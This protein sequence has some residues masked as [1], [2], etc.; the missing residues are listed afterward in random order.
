MAVITIDGPCAAG[1]TSIAKA[2]AKQTGFTYIDTGA[3]Y[4]VLAYRRREHP[5]ESPTS[6]GL[7]CMSGPDG[8]MRVYVN[9]NLIPDA[10]LRTPE[11]GMLASDISKE[12]GIRQYLLE[13]Q[14]GLMKSKDVI[15]E[16]RDTGSVVFPDAELKFYV[17]ADI[18]TRALRR[19]AQEPENT[20]QNVIAMLARRDAQD[21]DRQ[22]APLR[23]TTDMVY[24]DT[25]NLTLDEVTAA[26]ASI[27][28]T[29]LGIHGG[30]TR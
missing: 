20:F 29:R 12:P 16:G 26:M 10:N 25:T 15:F 24:L 6:L 1:K 2:L 14:H 28:K 27:A 30:G 21:K 23:R 22:L 9:G 17:D 4:R 8:D 3:L 18:L 5:N 7:T 11:M 13:Y 19:H